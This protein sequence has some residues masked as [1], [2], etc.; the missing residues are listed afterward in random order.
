MKSIKLFR[1]LSAALMLGLLAV[2]TQAN[3]ARPDAEVIIEW[4]ELLQAVVPAG[5]LSPPRYYAMLHVAMFDAANSV[6][7]GYG[8]YRFSA[9]CAPGASSEAAAA[10]AGHDILVALFTAPDQVAKFDAALQARLNNINPYRARLGIPVGKAIAKQVLDWRA[11]DGWSVT[12]PAFVLPPIPG[13][14]Q[15]TPPAFGPPQFTQFPTTQPFALLTPTQF[16]PRR[17]PALDSA[18]YADGFNEVKRLGSATSVERTAEQTQLARLFASVISSTVHWGLWN[19]VARDTARDHHLSLLDTARLFALMNVSIHD[20]VQTSH[21]SKFVYAL[22]RPVTAI[23][24]AD[25][26]MNPLTDADPTWLPLITTP[27]Y[28]SYSGN[29]ACVG[30]SA[31]RAL[32]LFYGTDAVTFNAVWIGSGGNPD[33]TRPYS[34]FWQMAEDQANSRVFGGIHYR[35]DNEASQAT[36]PRVPE[37]VFT[38]YMLPRG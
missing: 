29:M 15:P 33:V 11:S 18:E 26:D 25:E 21:T 32:G 27:P 34:S 38:H 16:L 8:R 6:E 14:Y 19:H 35:F 30:A 17:P 10:Q 13:L 7:R 3:P 1:N 24:R 9:W 37:F 36:C 2:A 31:A 20:G 4:N 5:G 22:W 28:P 23:R 12:P